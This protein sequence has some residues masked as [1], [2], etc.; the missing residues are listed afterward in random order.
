MQ[1]IDIIR[2]Q[3]MRV[4]ETTDYRHMANRDM[5]GS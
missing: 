4:T 3:K 1:G 2:T 5:I